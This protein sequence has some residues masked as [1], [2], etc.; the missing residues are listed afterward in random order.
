[1]NH[2]TYKSHLL[3]CLEHIEKWKKNL[4]EFGADETL[5]IPE[6]S[7]SEIFDEFLTR[8]ERT[9][10]IY[11]PQYCGQMMKPP[12]AAASLAYFAAML[13]NPN[14]HALDG[15]PE[16]SAMEKEAVRQIAEMFGLHKYL[17]HLT[18]GGTMANLEALWVAREIHPDKYIAFSSESHYTHERMC[19]LLKIPYIVV[20]T[21]SRGKMNIDDLEKK[22]SR[23]PIGTVV[24]TLGTTGR[25]ALDPVD[26]LIELKKKHN[27][28]IHADAAY[29]GYYTLLAD[30]E[31]SLIEREPFLHITSCDSIV[32]DPHKHGL[33]PYGCGCVVFSDPEVGKYYK[34]DSPYTY[35]ISD[36]LHLGEISLECSRAGA[37]AAAL[38]VTIQCFPLKPDM[39]MGPILRKTRKAALKIAE[40]ITQSRY[41][42]LL[43]QPELDIVVFFP[44]IAEFT[45]SAVSKASER[46]FNAAMDDKIYLAKMNIESEK[47]VRNH[48]EFEADKEY[49]TILRSCLMK[50]EHLSYVDNIYAVLEEIVKKQI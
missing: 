26:K 19:K 11:H 7:I 3:N 6:N 4:P 39:G 49:T 43:S 44:K 42:E 22:I 23:Y 48:P 28:R 32:I 17:G 8:L 1:M 47:I 36:V 2:N 15:G 5:S 24:A 34:H 41:Y 16:T 33:Q 46:I 37:A 50:P 18:G 27:F 31:E 25:G 12:H 20:D 45:S 14:N 40:L 10:P 13:Q 9:Y 29:G 21:D 30:D 35:F 38:L